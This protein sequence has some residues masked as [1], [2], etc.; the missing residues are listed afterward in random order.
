[1]AGT[2][3]RPSIENSK[4]AWQFARAIISDIMIYNRP[5]IEEGIEKDNLFMTMDAE[6]E[7]G[8]ELFKRR[9]TNDI[10]KLNIYDRVIVDK[11]V[12]PNGHIKSKMW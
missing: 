12:K 9:V 4:R 1:M 7:E 11:L 8:R 5:K 3:G 10:F 6:I 2:P